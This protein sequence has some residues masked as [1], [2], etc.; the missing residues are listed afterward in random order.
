MLHQNSDLMTR[1]VDIAELPV[2]EAPKHAVAKSAPYRAAVEV[3]P[4]Q[5]E[6]VAVKPVAASAPAKKPMVAI[7]VA[8]VLVLAV[9]GG[10]AWFFLDKQDAEPPAAPAPA[11]SVASAQPNPDAEDPIR[12]EINR[13]R[14]GGANQSSVATAPSQPKMQPV[15][16]EPETP[17]EK[18]L[19]RAAKEAIEL[20]MLA[21]KSETGF[22]PIFNGLDINNW[23]GDP[24][25]WSVEDGAITVRTPADARENY[26]T[27]L[28][29][30]GGKLANFELR[31]LYKIKVLKENKQA[32]A[33]VI[34]RGRKIRDYLAYGYE[35]RVSAEGQNSGVLT[36]ADRLGLISFTQKTIVR[37]GE[38]SSDR[39]EIVGNMPITFQDVMNIVKKDDWNEC[40]ITADKNQ[41]THKINGQLVAHLTDENEKKRAMDGIMALQIYTGPGR[42]TFAQFKDIQLK[43]L[44]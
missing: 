22:T 39:L 29:Y 37:E 17:E 21:N 12:A 16:Q 43:R 33:G 32:Y 44:P 20:A 11:P 4:A 2:Q 27:C 34:Y 30:N 14:Q 25:Y 19:R 8:A 10:A 38:K 28:F 18:R 5:Q 15:E 6:L 24:R 40:I 7:A 23:N 13:L 41:F 42:V 31:F 36:S 3:V 9:G 35:C 1:S 26:T